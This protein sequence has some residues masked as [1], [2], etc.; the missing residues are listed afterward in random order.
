MKRRDIVHPK[1]VNWKEIVVTW[2]L[3]TGKVMFTQV[4]LFSTGKLPFPWSCRTGTCVNNDEDDEDDN[5]G[6]GSGDGSDFDGG[7]DG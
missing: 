4:F 7:S 6:G 1:V 5:N 3:L 2:I